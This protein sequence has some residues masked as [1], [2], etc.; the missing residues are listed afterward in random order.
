M[1]GGALLAPAL[2][3]MTGPLQTTTQAIG[4]LMSVFT[5]STA[6][7]T[8]IIGVFIDRV[9]RKQ[10]LVPSLVIYGLTGIFSYFIADFSSLL[11]LRFVQGIGVAGMMT[12]AFLIIGDAYKGYESVQ[13][14]SKMSMSLAIGAIS[15]PLIG[16]SLASMGW[17][18]P[19]LFYVLSLPF[20][21]I[22]TVI[23]P[24]TRAQNQGMRHRGM[25]DVMSSLRDFPIICTIFMGF[26]IF[27]LLYSLIIYVPFMLKNEFGFLSGES[28]LMLAIEGIAVVIMASRVSTLAN[29]FSIIRV[30]TAGFLMVGISLV[31][32]PWTGTIIAI[33]L[34]LLLFGAGYG[35]AQT[36]ID[37]Q[38]IHVTPHHSKG[39]VLSIHTCM[40]YM[41]MSLSPIFL[42]IILTYTGLQ[43]V[44]IIAGVFGIII[45]ILTY[46]LKNRFNVPVV[47]SVSDMNITEKNEIKS[48]D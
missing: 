28:G 15:A 22:V 13:A 3:E 47:Y 16:G 35:L 29:R 8:L 21:L 39:G 33:F 9:N 18:T 37:A 1:A 30:I 6:V 41:G 48:P 40:K 11:I 5:F 27:F 31:C 2:P 10:I 4:L 45:A 36:A 32:M 38:I 19:F 44:F 34:L 46:G 23:L 26:A 24:E 25:K 14:I 17:N 7:F 42:G 20:A 12:L 43:S